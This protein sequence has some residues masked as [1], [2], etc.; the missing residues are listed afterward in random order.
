MY[1]GQLD[2]QSKACSGDF[3]VHEHRRIPSKPLRAD[4]DVFDVQT[5]VR[6][7]GPLRARR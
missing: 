4:A 7:L 3:I 2:L 5:T 6:A 1:L